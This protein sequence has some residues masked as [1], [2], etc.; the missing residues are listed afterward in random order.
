VSKRISKTDFISKALELR[1]VDHQF[2]SLRFVEPIYGT[3]NVKIDGKEYINF[4]TN[5]YLGLSSN[6]EVIKRS[7]DFT[8]T[9][10]AGSGASRLVSG[11]FSI[12]QQLEEKLALTFGVEA[13]LLFNTGFQANTTILSTLADRNS[14]ILADK[15]CHNSLIQGALLSRATFKRFNHNDLDHLESLLVEAS[16]TSYNRVWIVSETIFSM[17]GDQSDVSAL[18]DL[19][20]KYDALFYSDDAHALGV[21]G[22]KGLG[23]N[24]GKSGIDVSIGTFGKAFGSFGAFVGCSL[25]MKNY[26][27]NF[28]PGFIYTTSLPPAVLGAIDASLDL[29][30]K[31]EEDRKLLYKNITFLKSEVEKLE[32]KIGDSASQIIPIIIGS[33]EKTMDLSQY[34]EE[35]GIWA[36]A[37]RPP[38]VENNASRIR[39]T[40]N[41][42][43]SQSDIN[44]LLTTLSSWKKK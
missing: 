15:K 27:V 6:L 31:M 17:D 37:I 38:T 41:T 4:C 36:S 33:E 10:G 21:L 30:P 44:H 42:N 2:R 24:F 25:E 40:I 23:L 32:F 34:L 14:L 20:Q 19:A 22:E 39:I 9:Y 43:H 16:S 35:H 12:H 13:V 11:S 29:I 26:L 18:I 8:N 3:S 7:T 5:D 1:R 28:C